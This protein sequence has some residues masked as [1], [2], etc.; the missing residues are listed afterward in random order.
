MSTEEGKETRLGWGSSSPG[1]RTEVAC[2]SSKR[3][4]NISK[5]FESVWNDKLGLHSIW[6]N[7][8]THLFTHMYKTATDTHFEGSHAFF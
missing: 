3:S 1:R 5:H 7:F 8:C 2:S 4:Q 6:L